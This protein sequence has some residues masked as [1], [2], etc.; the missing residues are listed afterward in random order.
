M[1]RPAQPAELAPSFVY[2]ASEV[3]NIIVVVNA[4]HH[5]GILFHKWRNS[6]RHWRHA[7]RIGMTVQHPKIG[8]DAHPH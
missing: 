6:W 3:Y 4:H 8:L 2:L 5:S 1:G 7:P